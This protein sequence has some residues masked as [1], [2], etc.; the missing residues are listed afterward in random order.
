MPFAAIVVA[1]LMLLIWG[2]GFW[3]IHRIFQ[4]GWPEETKHED[5]AVQLSPVSP[6]Q[7]QGDVPGGSVHGPSSPAVPDLP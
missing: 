6:A 4:G 7:A 3:Y 2:A 1:I 5:Q